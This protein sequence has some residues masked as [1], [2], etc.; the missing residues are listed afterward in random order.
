[1]R[2]HQFFRPYGRCSD[3]HYAVTSSHAN[4]A[5]A[6]FLEE[7]LPQFGPYQDAMRV[8]E[9]FLF[10]AVVSMYLNN[11]LLCLRRCVVM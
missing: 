3:F 2:L 7:Y 11:G 4:Q 5:W 6:Q 8:Q 10:H 9:P 1:M